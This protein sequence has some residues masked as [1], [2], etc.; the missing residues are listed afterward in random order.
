MS[1]SGEAVKKRNSIVLLLWA[2]KIFKFVEELSL[3]AA[4]AVSIPIEVEGWGSIL[5]HN[6]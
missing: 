6:N 4:D 3:L 2:K 5:H 1:D